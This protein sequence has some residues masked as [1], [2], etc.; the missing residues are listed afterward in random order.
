MDDFIF[1]LETL[2]EQLQAA[3]DEAAPKLEE[4]LEKWILA[5][6]RDAKANLNRPRWFLQQN[7]SSK[8]KAFQ[9]NRKVWAMTGFRSRNKTDKRD[10]G[11][12]GRFHEAGWEPDRKVVKVP[13]HFLKNAKKQNLPTLEKEL[14]ATLA[15]VMDL[16]RRIT[17]S[18]RQSQ[19]R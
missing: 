17:A 7:I 16:T 3:R 4:T 12:Y 18:R 14:Q 9:K 6:A 15:D 13:R 10:P 8:V 19:S 1:S 5:V 11:Y 2:I